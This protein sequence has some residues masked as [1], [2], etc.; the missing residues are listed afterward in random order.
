MARIHRYRIASAAAANVAPS[1]PE[2]SHLEGDEPM[3]SGPRGGG[4]EPVRIGQPGR[5]LGGV[6]GVRNRRRQSISACSKQARQESNLQP[7]VLETGA[8][9]IELRTSDY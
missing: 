5:E 1:A 9:P 8:L 2:T 3:A 7:P 6:F 4:H